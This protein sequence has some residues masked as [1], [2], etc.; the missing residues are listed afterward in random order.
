VLNKINKKRQRASKCEFNKWTELRRDGELKILNIVTL[1]QSSFFRVGRPLKKII[2]NYIVWSC[3]GAVYFG[4]WPQPLSALNFV[5][6]REVRI[7]HLVDSVNIRKKH[8]K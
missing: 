1:N 5:E 8:V 3:D 6:T 4:L 7:V 2:K